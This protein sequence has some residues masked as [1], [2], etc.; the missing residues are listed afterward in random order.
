MVE[1]VP[2]VTRTNY[3]HHSAD[4]SDTNRSD[5]S[6]HE[7]LST[8][9]TDVLND[10]IDHMKAT[11]V[12][13]PDSASINLMKKTILYIMNKLQSLNTRRIGPVWMG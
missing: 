8:E 2:N 1:H 12:D 7:Q 5:S 9:T 6:L 3:T 10:T 13:V 11:N 4:M